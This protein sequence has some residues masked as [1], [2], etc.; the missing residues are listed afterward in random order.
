MDNIPNIIDI[1]GYCDDLS[2]ITNIDI[3]SIKYIVLCN[4]SNMYGCSQSNIS[5]PEALDN[6]ETQICSILDESQSQKKKSR[7]MIAS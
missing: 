4:F 6:I 2:K 5:L 7:V 3:N 1:D